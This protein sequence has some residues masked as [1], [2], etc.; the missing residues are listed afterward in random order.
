M[1]IDLLKDQT[2]TV[3]L[4]DGSHLVLSNVQQLT[5]LEHWQGGALLSLLSLP[6]PHDR[7]QLTQLEQQAH[8]DCSP[9]PPVFPTS[10]TL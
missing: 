5:R 9:P 8:H 2:V 4:P 6:T 1:T 7:H 10:R 3:L